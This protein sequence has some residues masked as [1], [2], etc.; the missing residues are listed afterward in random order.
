MCLPNP[1]TTRMLACRQTGAKNWFVLDHNITDHERLTF[2]YIHDSWTT[3][4]PGSIWDTANFPTSQTFFNGP[5]VSVVARLTSTISPTLL[6][7]FVASYTTDHI[8]FKSVGLLALPSGYSQGYLYNNGAGG[9]LPAINIGAGTNVYSGGFGQDPQGIWPEGPYNSNPTY[10][11]RDN[12]TKIRGT[13]QSAI[14]CLFRCRSKERTQQRA[15]QRLAHILQSLQQCSDWRKASRH[16]Q[17]RLP[18][19][20][21]ATLPALPRAA[22]S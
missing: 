9:K 22:T 12:M 6:N 2:R 21:W 3:L 8:S 14:R 1:S 5:G 7:E 20:S 11:Y 13:A 16:W 15:G 10:T 4:E 19:S 18:I 17:S